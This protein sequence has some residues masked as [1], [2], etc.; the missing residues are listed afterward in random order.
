[1]KVISSFLVIS[2]NPAAIGRHSEDEAE[3]QDDQSGV[4]P[5]PSAPK[6]KKQVTDEL[7]SEALEKHSGN[8]KAAAAEVGLSER[9]IYRWLAAAKSSN[10][11]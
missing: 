3:W 7:I 2:Q 8:V 10:Q 9:T 1:M 6:T 5:A 11:K 4:T